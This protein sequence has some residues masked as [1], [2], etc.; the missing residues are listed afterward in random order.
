MQHSIRLVPIGLWA[1]SFSCATITG[2]GTNP[3]YFGTHYCLTSPPQVFLRPQE[4]S[5][6][7]IKCGTPATSDFVPI[8]MRTHSFVR[9]NFTARTRSG[10][11]MINVRFP[12]LS[13]HE[14]PS[15]ASTFRTHT[16][17]HRCIWISRRHIIVQ[18]DSPW[19]QVPKDRPA[20]FSRL[21]ALLV[22]VYHFVDASINS[23]VTTS[24]ESVQ[25]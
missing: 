8:R 11:R 25:F 23:A 10:R 1:C 4:Q 9:E 14:I 22:S 13:K 16:D 7:R 21:Q 20:F 12:S 19:F 24:P 2:H 5:T 3:E 18:Q 6:E 17:H 15:F